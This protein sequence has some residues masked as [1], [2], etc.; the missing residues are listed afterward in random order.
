MNHNNGFCQP[1][2]PDLPR[3][4][5]ERVHQLESELADS[6]KQLYELSTEVPVSAS[7]LIAM[8]LAKYSA[9]AEIHIDSRVQAQWSSYETNVPLGNSFGDSTCTVEGHSTRL[10]YKDFTLEGIAEQIVGN[11]PIISQDKFM[12]MQALGLGDAERRKNISQAQLAKHGL[13]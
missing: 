7:K 13:L 10:I 5:V 9:I 6:R 8:L 3:Y 4:S 11:K 1:P 12:Y 2:A